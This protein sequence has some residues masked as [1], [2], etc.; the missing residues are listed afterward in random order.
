MITMQC[1]RVPD[2]DRQMDEHHG[3]S[4]TI[5]YND[6]IERYKPFAVPAL[7]SWTPPPKY[8]C[9][10]PCLMFKRKQQCIFIHCIHYAHVYAVSYTHLTLPTNREV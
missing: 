4:A 10:A 7:E 2:T 9:E 3:N 5:R 8:N 6:C 1:T